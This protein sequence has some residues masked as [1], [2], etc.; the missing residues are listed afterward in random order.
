M[1]GDQ[2]V[3]E[4]HQFVVEDHIRA[5]SGGIAEPESPSY[6]DAVTTACPV[7]QQ[8]FPPSRRPKFCS[9]KCRAAAYRRRRDAA[10]PAVAVPKSQPRRPI[11]VLA[12]SAINRLTSA[13]YELVI[14]G[15]SYQRRQ[16]PGG[17]IAGRA[18]PTRRPKRP[19]GES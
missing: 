7:C 17:V 19:G 5:G 4:D 18:E 1:S 10:R 14:E 13:A 15:E 6:H 11:T 16:K 2:F 12:Q 8:T 9:D 3:V